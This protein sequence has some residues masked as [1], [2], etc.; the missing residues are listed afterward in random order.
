MSIRFSP[1]VGKVQLVDRAMLTCQMCRK[2][3]A[4]QCSG[5]ELL[6]LVREIEMNETNLCTNPLSILVSWQTNSD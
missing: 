2:G 4:P 3:Q 1:G 5:I 6:Y